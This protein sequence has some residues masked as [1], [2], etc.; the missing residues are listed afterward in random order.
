MDVRK[1]NDKSIFFAIG[2]QSSVNTRW[3]CF[4]WRC[5]FLGPPVPSSFCSPLWQSALWPLTSSAG[6]STLCFVCGASSGSDCL[7]ILTQRSN[8]CF[9]PQCVLRSLGLGFFA[10]YNACERSKGD[11]CHLDPPLDSSSY[12]IN[13]IYWKNYLSVWYKKYQK[14]I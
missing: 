1:L 14:I 10:S 3:L 8:C 2:P 6:F 12:L 9:V 13:D 7:C 11:R 5:S 4:V